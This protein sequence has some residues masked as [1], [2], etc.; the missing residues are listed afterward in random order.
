MLAP[1]P[2]QA[3]FTHARPAGVRRQLF[4]CIDDNYFS[5]ST[6]ITF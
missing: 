2:S 4:L 5:R 3:V 1:W 6:T